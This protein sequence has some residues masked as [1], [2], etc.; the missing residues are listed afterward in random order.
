MNLEPALQSDVKSEREKQISY[1]NAYI[2]NLE[3]W[4]GWTYLQGSSGD[5]DTE[6]RLVDTVGGGDGGINWASSI[7]T[8]TLPYMNQRASGTWLL[9]H[10]ELNLVL[11]DNPKGWE[12]GG[13]FKK[14]RVYV[15]LWLIHVMYGR[16][17]H[18]ILKQLSSN[19]KE[20][21]MQL[22]ITS[23]CIAQGTIFN[24]LW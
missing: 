17:Q 10:R 9:W 6:N 12:V 23:Y 4:Y 13:R 16:N 1:I 15:Y 20:N 3:R 24:I 18:N 7:E 11:S 22:T 8:Y 5:A 19:E 14:E 21:M 2:W